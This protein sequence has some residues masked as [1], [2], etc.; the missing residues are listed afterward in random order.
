VGASAAAARYCPGSNS[1]V[2]FKWGVP[3]SAASSNSGNVYMQISAPS[4]YAW[5]GLGIGSQMSGAEIFLIYKDGSG[6]VTLS[7]RTASGHVQPT[8]ERRSQVELLAGSGV[9]G[10]T[11]T[12]NIRCGDCSRLEL[13]GS[14]RWIAAWRNSGSLESDSTSASI[15]EHNSHDQFTLDFSRASIA[16]DSNPFVESSSGGSGG[17]GSGGSGSGSDGSGSGSGTDSD[18]DSDSDGDSSGG[19]VTGN[20]GPSNTVIT[21]HGIVMTVAF[22]ALYPIGALLMPLVGKW[23]IHGTVQFVAFL[24]MWAGF[25]LGYYYANGTNTVSHHTDVHLSVKQKRTDHVPASF[26]TIPT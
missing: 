5:A 15:S 22:A 26:S 7:T 6:N 14:N 12:A 10:D 17:S 24:A 1:E 16:T 18:S 2:C 13:G 23:F 19:A 21:A 3:E 4:S 25:G 9:D 20:S 11:M 8:Y